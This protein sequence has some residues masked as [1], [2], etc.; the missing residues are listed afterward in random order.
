MS[1]LGTKVWKDR[2]LAL[3]FVVLILLLIGR[4]FT[5][6]GILDYIEILRLRRETKVERAKDMALF[7]YDLAVEKL[8]R[9]TGCDTRAMA[10][11]GSIG[12]VSNGEKYQSASGIV[13][14]VDRVMDRNVSGGW[15]PMKIQKTVIPFSMVNPGRQK[16]SF[17]RIWAMTFISNW[18]SARRPMRWLANMAFGY[19]TKIRK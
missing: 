11:A 15:F 14:K 17:L 2:E 1:I 19:P 12:N 6:I 10:F 18:S 3:A 4:I 5:C 13:Q 16:S 7:V 8:Q 9:L